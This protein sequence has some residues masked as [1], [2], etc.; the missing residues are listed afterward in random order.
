MPASAV[1]PPSFVTRTTSEPLPEML[2]DYVVYD[3][4][5]A[6]ARGMLVL[7]AASVRAAGYFANDWS[8]PAK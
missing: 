5:V 1:S 7:G 2:P 3:R 6:S 4:G 8:L